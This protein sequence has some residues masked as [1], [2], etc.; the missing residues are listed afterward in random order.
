MANS[1]THD[2]SQAVIDRMA[3]S[4]DFQF[5]AAMTS[6]GKHMNAFLEEMQS[7]SRVSLNSV[8]CSA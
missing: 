1:E 4:E 8:A 3:D 7:T 6:L 2:I 5:K